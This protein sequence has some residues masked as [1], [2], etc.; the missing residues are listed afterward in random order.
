MK[1]LLSEYDQTILL[2]LKTRKAIQ[3]YEHFR[4]SVTILIILKCFK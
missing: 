2:K 3:T 1:K 4:G